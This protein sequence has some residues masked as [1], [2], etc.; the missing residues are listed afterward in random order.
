MRLNSL[1]LSPNSSGFRHIRHIYFNSN[2]YFSDTKHTEVPVIQ[3]IPFIYPS[4]LE[5]QRYNKPALS[6]YPFNSENFNDYKINRIFPVTRRQDFEDHSPK[7]HFRKHLYTP[8]VLARKSMKTN[9]ISKLT[10]AS[11]NSYKSAG[12]E[13]FNNFKP[14]TSFHNVNT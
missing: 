6:I 11:E 4:S 7:R 13:N 8:A 2:I 5:V 3:R 10:E 1:G 9:I 12:K 14:F